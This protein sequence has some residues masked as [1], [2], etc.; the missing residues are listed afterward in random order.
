MRE[1]PGA[2][3]LSSL[4]QAI[5]RRI[6]FGEDTPVAV[7]DMSSLL[8]KTLDWEMLCGECGIMF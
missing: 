3:A 5:G 4:F 7:V 8:Q 2:G 6:G 1:N